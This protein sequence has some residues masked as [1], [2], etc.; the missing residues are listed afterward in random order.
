MSELLRFQQSHQQVTEQEYA[1]S[2]EHNIFSHAG[3]P[4]F[5]TFAA[6]DV[7]NGDGKEEHC[8]GNENEVLHKNLLD[9]AML[10]GEMPH[11]FCS[12]LAKTGPN[13]H[14]RSPDTV[15]G[16]GLGSNELYLRIL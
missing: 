4:L 10:T 2:D 7:K 13:G 6:T 15:A 14:H 9:Y 11:D 8:Y 5:Q 12:L 1:D 16:Q 3:S